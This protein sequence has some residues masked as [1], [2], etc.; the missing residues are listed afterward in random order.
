MSESKTVKDLMIGVFEYPHL[1]YWFTIRQGVQLIKTSF[2]TPKKYLDP[3]A[4]LVFNEKYNLLGTLTLKEILRGI[5][6]KFMSSTGK[7]QGYA[8]EEA[9]LSIIWDSLFNKQS[10][11]MAERPIS[12]VMVPTQ[13]FVDPDESITKAAY[14]LLRHDL[15]LLPVLEDKKKLIGIVR[16]LEVFDEL[17]NVILK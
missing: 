2:F 15:V 3:M 6:P 9:E 11:E 16:M 12:E 13:H 8:P 5:E 1:P 7:A 14:L 17:T 4:I 10:K